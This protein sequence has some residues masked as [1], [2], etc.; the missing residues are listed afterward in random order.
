MREKRWSDL[1]GEKHQ[2]GGPGRGGGRGAEEEGGKGS[3]EKIARNY[4]IQL[5]LTVY[6]SPASAFMIFKSLS[7]PQK[8]SIGTIETLCTGVG[9]GSATETG[10]A[11]GW[12]VEGRTAPPQSGT[13]CPSTATMSRGGTL[14]SSPVTQFEAHTHAL[15]PSQGK[16]PS[17]CAE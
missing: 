3:S 14:N 8:N 11:S 6:Q 5:L 12:D 13:K 7:L 16:R 15:T 17:H 2:G 9:R 1:S 4:S 10:L